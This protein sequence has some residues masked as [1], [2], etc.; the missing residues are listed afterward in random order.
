MTLFSIGRRINTPRVHDEKNIITIQTLQSSLT[1]NLN[2]LHQ[3]LSQSQSFTRKPKANQNN[4]EKLYLTP[5]PQPHLPPTHTRH[6][7]IHACV[8]AKPALIQLIL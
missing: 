8:Q 5:K 6:N 3:N 2:Q 1:S 4:K 7:V